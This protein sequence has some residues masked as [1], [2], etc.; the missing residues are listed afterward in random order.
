MTLTVALT[1]A[2]GFIGQ[3]L[4]PILL[5]QLPSGATVKLLVRP[6][7]AAA[8][9]A[10]TAAYGSAVTLV[11]GDLRD[12]AVCARLVEDA[13]AVIHLAGR[14]K[15]RQAADF[16]A[17]NATATAQLAAAVPPSTPFLLVSSLAA[18]HPELSPYAASK[19][20]AEQALQDSGLSRATVLRPTAVY[21]PG[22]RELQPL[23]NAL[24]HGWA[25]R[26]S[27]RHAQFSLIFVD[28]LAC[29]LIQWLRC[30]TV[31]IPASRLFGQVFEVSDGANYDWPTFARI[32]NRLRGQPVRTVGVPG[33]LLYGLG[34]LHA[35]W[36]RL[37]G[38]DPML[39]PSKVNELRHA[40]WACDNRPLST[41][42]GWRPHVD[43]PEGLRRTCL[44]ATPARRTQP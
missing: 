22:D 25:L 29:A 43:L 23:L 13:T 39:T 35:G 3:R 37:T 27:P 44:W 10:N 18:R 12:A 30:A 11:R 5:A 2:T 8:L 14:V 19:R 21:G 34:Y 32:A 24:G 6:T 15:A 40:N 33:P 1:G 4:L 36:S 16:F 9:A 31:P 26:V 7:K 41:A 20:A 42:L 28:D 38:G 17:D